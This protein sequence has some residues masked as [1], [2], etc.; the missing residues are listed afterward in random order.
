MDILLLVYRPLP[1]V[2]LVSIATVAM[3]TITM[4]NNAINMASADEGTKIT[5]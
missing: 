2:F 1:Q 5:V 4:V 3:V